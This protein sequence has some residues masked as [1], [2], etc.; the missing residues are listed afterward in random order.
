MDHVSILD[1]YEQQLLKVFSSH[2]L[3]NCGSLDKDG[4]IQLCYTLQLEEQGPELIRSVLSGK[5]SRATFGEF[6][7]ALLALLGK[8]QNKKNLL[9]SPLKENF[10]EKNSPDREV[11]PKYIYG[12]KK[13]G[14][15][16]RP[17]QDE[18]NNEENDTP[19]GKQGSPVQ[20]SNSQSE[21]LSKKRKTNYKLKRCTSLPGH[22][23]LNNTQGSHFISSNLASEPEI[24]CTEEM[25][26]EAWKKLG[27]GE[28][29]YLN[30]T[31]LVLVC[32]AIG[33]HKLADEIIKQLAVNYDKKI[34]FNEVL[35]VIQRDETWFDVLNDSPK[36][37]NTIN[38]RC[39]PQ[40]LFPDS[41]T[42]QYVTLGL[43]G[44]G[45]INAV[46][47]IEMWENVGIHAPKELIHELGFD[48]RKINIAE[49]AAVLEKQTR[50]MNENTRTEFQSPHI[51]LLQA[52]LT[53]Y[54]LEI[55]CLRN[56]LEQLQA[57]REKL[58]LDVTEANNRA[59]LL[60]QEVDDN[61][62]RME[63][64]TLNQV[65][66]LE[67]RHSDMIKDIA[68]QYSKD[69]E[70]LNSINESLE[71]KISTLETETAKLKS[72]L[73]V[74]QNYSLNV[75]I[76][77]QKL[78]GQI[79]EL[80][81]DKELLVNKVG[82]LEL[83]QQRI[84][85]MEREESELLLSKLSALQIKNSELKDRNDEME[86]EIESLNNQVMSMKTKTSSTP[87]RNYNTL[88]RSMEEDNISIIYEGVG[89]GAKRRS[90]CSPSKDVQLLRMT[91]GSPRLGKVRKC[92]TSRTP[93]NLEVPFTSNESGFDTE[94]ESL[95]TSTCDNEEVNRLQAKVAFLEQVLMQHNIPVPTYEESETLLTMQLTSRVK[96]LE[97]IITDTKNEMNKMLDKENEC[98]SC[99]KLRHVCE[100]LQNTVLLS[101]R[102]LHQETCVDYSFNSE[103]SFVEQECQTDL[104]VTFVEKKVRQLEEENQELSA[105]CTNL[106]DCIELLR[107]EYEKCEDYWQSKVD[108][109]RQAFEE[110]QKI[111]ADKLNEV[112]EKMHD[113]EEQFANQDMIDSRLPTI[114]ETDNLEKQFTDLEQEFEDYKMYHEGEMF[115]K[116]EEI[117]ILKE[118][119]TELA[120]KQQ[121]M[122][123]ASV[124]ADADV[125]EQRVLN[126]MKSFTSYVI[127]NTCRFSEEMLP[128]QP[129]EF[130][131]MGW[132]KGAVKSETEP[133]TIR[134]LL[135]TNW[136]YRNPNTNIETANSVG[137]L[138]PSTSSS[139]NSTPCRPK[140]TRKHDKN[141]YKKNNTEKDNKKTES[142]NTQ[143]QQQ[144]LPREQNAVLPLSAF[145]NIMG[146]KAYLEQ[147]VR[148][149]QMCMKQQHYHNEQ[150]LQHYCQHFRGE[151]NELQTKLKFCQE[152]LD[153]QMR[154]CNEQLEKLHR[155][156]MF[157]KD[158]YVENAYL[159]A[160]VERLEKQCRMFPQASS[161]TD[162]V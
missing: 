77:N 22:K 99:D 43:D 21:V 10:V 98:F 33:L 151:R 97:K 137:N 7:D 104:N 118:K 93:D 121:K 160:N 1:P 132:N 17:R 26:R 27:V 81:K 147:R 146:R 65:K 103:K 74:A 101:N 35:E 75:E 155:S 38:L 133:S 89:L 54:Q 47:L 145:N 113:F 142:T 140:R 122:H 13:Y 107:T 51:T 138:A 102:D 110:E 53:L 152:K 60:A 124:Q 130:S 62:V 5:K 117:S 139:Q 14:R 79:C 159:Y 116:E 91:D 128:P 18:I 76:E 131:N 134:S 32:D 23:D 48:S 135:P 94:P 111:S 156:D 161:S 64:N 85:D 115:K 96:E 16:T 56:I 3:D 66:L 20:R 42:F 25:L 126:K 78:S 71:E 19:Q 37:D 11:S 2:D 34:S 108:E 45:L 55:R 24:V 80:E 109:E 39:S 136:A 119:L 86:S 70:Q 36:K 105:K 83:E 154:I 90:D 9:E 87:T 112:L 114:A 8:M 88:D 127:E 84:R 12:S 141:M 50:T 162:S 52:N 143:H 148:Y 4:L 49:L 157:V 29:G 59:T 68:S 73:I 41:Q 92:F 57:E 149:L 58:K 63:Q 44:N 95:S 144:A 100:K 30:Q 158:L 40:E 150:T 72:D 28:D 82:T 15:R 125:E 129:L 61:H 69:K 120:L 6:K 46:T 106:G 123:E 153:Q 31:E 67:Q